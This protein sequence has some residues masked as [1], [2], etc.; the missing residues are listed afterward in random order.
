MGAPRGCWYDFVDAVSLGTQNHPVDVRKRNSRVNVMDPMEEPDLNALLRALAASEAGSFAAAAQQLGVSRQAI[1][2]SV[3]ALEAAVGA[4][5]FDRGARGLRP[6]SVGREVLRHA[7][8]LRAVE[9]SLAATLAQMRAEPT[10]SVRI[11]TPPLFGTFVLN[12]ALLRFAQKWPAVR[13]QVQSDV[14]RTDLVGD[15]FDLMIRIGSAPPEQHFARLLGHAPLVLCAPPSLLA[16]GPPLT[17]PELLSGM[18]LLEY[19]P[20]RSTQW[21][22]SGKGLDRRIDVDVRLVS[23]SAALMVE[24][25]LSG[26]GILRTP[27]LAVRELLASGRLVRVLPEWDMPLAEVWA[28]Y[29]HRTAGDP[30]L[31]ALLDEILMAFESKTPLA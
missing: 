8:A 30:T 17:T 5:V 12:A 4:P 19:G 22:F 16:E 21:G 10:G 24:A 1:H 14:R 31:G 9:R 20:R 25:C 3:E 11:A 6:T 23:D 7:A 26:M 13:V 28:V 29:G 15:D 18:A 27:E 2:R